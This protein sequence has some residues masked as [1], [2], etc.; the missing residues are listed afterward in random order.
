MQG[1]LGVKTL[2]EKDNSMTFSV[3]FIRNGPQP[4]MAP[5]LICISTGVRNN[6]VR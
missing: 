4:L 1:K 6:K 3:I 5:K 2:P